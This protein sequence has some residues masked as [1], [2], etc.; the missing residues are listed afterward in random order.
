VKRYD[1]KGEAMAVVNRRAKEVGKLGELL[2]VTEDVRHLTRAQALL[3]LDAGDRVEEGAERLGVTRQAVDN[4][5]ARFTARTA[6]GWESRVADGPRSG[7]PRTAFGS[8]AP[9]LEQGIETDPRA[10]GYR[11]TLWTAPLLQHY[12]AQEPQ[13]PV[14]TKSI[15]RALARLRM[16]WQRPRHHLALRARD[17]SQA[18]GGLTA[19]FGSAHER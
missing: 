9:L 11:A 6:V 3:W 4:W 5:G 10:R 16:T 17:W 12:L 13:R 8:I 19:A 2:T 1:P 18:Q 14:S 7:R 15:Q